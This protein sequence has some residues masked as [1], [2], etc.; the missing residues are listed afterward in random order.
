MEAEAG[1]TLIQQGKNGEIDENECQLAKILRTPVL[2]DI[3]YIMHIY[4]LVGMP[5]KEELLFYK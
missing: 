3:K 1:I 4:L 2:R 5:E